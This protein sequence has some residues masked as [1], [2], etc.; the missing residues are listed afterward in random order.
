M[1]HLPQGPRAKGSTPSMLTKHLKGSTSVLCFKGD[2]LGPLLVCDQGALGVDEY[3]NI[4]HDSLFSLIDDL[5]EPPEYPGTI[6]VMSKTPL[7][8]CKMSQIDRSSWIPSR[9]S[10][11]C[12]GVAASITRSQSY[13]KPLG[14]LQSSLSQEVYRDV[15]SSIE[16]SGSSTQIHSSST[17]CVVF[18]GS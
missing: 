11:N 9:E 6:Q 5:L 18:S 7:S 17:G 16:E 4:I 14:P 1:G 8:L 15:Q 13:R 3:E 10:H 12:H 2:R